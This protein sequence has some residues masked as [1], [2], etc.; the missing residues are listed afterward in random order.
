MWRA[1]VEGEDLLMV[2]QPLRIYL[3]GPYSNESSKIVERNVKSV[4]RA[5][6]SVLKKGHYPFIPHLT[7]FVEL[8]SQA[9][10]SG[11]KWEDY[12]DW[13]LAW[14][15]VCDAVLFLGPSRGA[16]LELEVGRELNKRIFFS[17]DE[18]P[19]LPTRHTNLPRLLGATV[20]LRNEAFTMPSFSS[21]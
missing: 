20:G 21:P 10:G 16:R 3:A 6:I 7:H 13:D 18:I 2:E 8:V 15:E 17:V 4:I 5:G 19:T 9:D 12:I 1:Q 11:L 14:L